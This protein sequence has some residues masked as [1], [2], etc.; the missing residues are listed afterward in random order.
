MSRL[1]NYIALVFLW[2]FSL[3]P[4][5]ILYRY[6]DILYHI[7]RLI[8]YRRSV[9]NE[10]LRYAYPDKSDEDIREMRLKFYRGFC[11]III[12]T[13]KFQTMSERQLRKRFTFK[14]IEYVN[15]VAE[16]GKDVVAVMGHYACWEWMSSINLHARM[17]CCATYRP[18]KNKIFDKHMLKVRSRWGSLNF[19]MQSTMRELVKLRQNDQRFL[20]GLLADQSPDKNKI[21]YWTKFLN[22]NT[23]VL[24]GP[25]KMAKA[26]KA[27]VVFLRV[28]RI[29]RGYYEVNVIPLTEDAAATSDYEI[30]EK[31]LQCLEN[32]IMERPEDWL[33]SHKRWKYSETRE[34]TT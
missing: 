2:L 24:L 4:F 5:F 25:E 33:W 27:V 23:A 26:F 17:Q 21:Q 22:Q 19:T 28:S 7:I 20:I 13:I 11:D 14:N 32:I 9:I 6:S 18:L 8:G 12:E 30:T 29:K 34:I 10:N 1:G 3:Q 16:A 31:H 15:T